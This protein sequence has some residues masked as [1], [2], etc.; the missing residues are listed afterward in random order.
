MVRQKISAWPFFFVWSLYS[1]E[2]RCFSE[3]FSFLKEQRMEDE[4]EW[5]FNLRGDLGYNEKKKLRDTGG[6]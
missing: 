2:T 4:F 6:R 3:A 1:S 5:E